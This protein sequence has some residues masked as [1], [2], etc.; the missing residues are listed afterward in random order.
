MFLMLSHLDII[1]LVQTLYPERDSAP[2][3]TGSTDPDPAPPSTAGS[4]TLNPSD[5]GSVVAPSSGP[6]TSGT[7]M[8]SGTIVDETSDIEG[9]VEKEELKNFVKDE[10]VGP[11]FK[12]PRTAKTKFAMLLKNA[13]RKLASLFGAHGQFQWHSSSKAWAFI[14]YSNQTP[15]LT[16]D[17]N[18]TREGLPGISAKSPAFEAARGYSSTEGYRTLKTG[19]TRLIADIDRLGNYRIAVPAKA[20]FTQI[21]GDHD[22]LELLMVEAMTR[23]QTGLNFGAAHFWWNIRSI[24]RDYLSSNHPQDSGSLLQSVADD[25]RSSA[26]TA[27]QAARANEIQL[28]SLKGLQEYQTS[29]LANMDEQRKALRVKMWYVSDVRHSASYEEALYVTRALRAM[30]STKRAKQPGS[31]ANW[32]RQRLR[33]SS[34]YTK[35]DLQTLEALSAPKNLGGQSKL[36]DEQIEITSRWLT[37]RSIENF[38]KGEE[39]IHRFCFEVQKCLGKIAGVSLLESPVLWSSN[40]FKRERE[41]FDAQRPPS[42]VPRSSYRGPTSP[43]IPYE[44]GRLQYSPRQ[45]LDPPT[46]DFVGSKAKQAAN[47]FGGFWNPS[48]PSPEPTG[49]GLHGFH[50]PPQPL[51]PTPTTPSFWSNGPFNSSSPMSASTAPSFSLVLNRETEASPAKKAFIDHVKSSLCSLL[52]SDLGY[53]LWNQGTETDCWI[54]EYAVHMSKAAPAR[55]ASDKIKVADTASQEVVCLSGVS[56]QADTPNVAQAPGTEDRESG[57]HSGVTDLNVDT[58]ESFPFSDAYG[59]LLLRMSLCN[60]PYFKLQLLF[61]LEDLISQSIQQFSTTQCLGR[62]ADSAARG[63]HSRGN[64]A[65]RGTS[66]PRTKAT[67]LEE[68]IANCTER[69][70]GTLRSRTPR[71]APSLTTLAPELVATDIAGTDEI[72]ETLLS[73]FRDTKLRPKTLFRD[74][75]YI[76]AFVSPDVLDRTAQGKAFWDVGLAAL[77]LKEDLCTS[78]INRANEITAY[79]ISTSKLVEPTTDSRLV[80]TTLRDAANLWLIAAKEGSPVAAR[81]LGLFYLTHPE[82]LPRVTLPFSKS[83]DVFKSAVSSDT[84][85][86]DKEK[87]A[88]DPLTFAVVFHWMEIAANGGDKDARD[89]LRA[90]GEL[91]AKR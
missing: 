29:V 52:I 59:A 39:R 61:E 43:P 18:M 62:I 35:S 66:V 1:G 77:A 21:T 15:M 26:E 73:I 90:N 19:I 65:L 68:V 57:P 54:N 75:Q 72:V 30:A 22:S 25:L 82:L 28:R 64:R 6:S 37:R 27:A 8:I 88:L 83:G 87:G 51:P 7:S 86:G 4:S 85:A 84:W 13:S 78:T 36:A 81:E 9:A 60:D 14:Y 56:P 17:Q 47:S 70:A 40:L 67:S 91:S 3:S 89:F 80:S 48:Q 34:P 50:P 16:M 76:A 11:P 79:H 10:H 24:Y 33:G 63:R 46:M 69:R 31:M 49:L 74:L 71:S 5:A 12:P 32:A 23:A 38:C 44:Y 55:Y 42:R 20:R 53:L 58:G 41:S 45:S 2:S